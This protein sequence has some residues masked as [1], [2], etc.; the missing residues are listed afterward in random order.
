MKLQSTACPCCSDKEYADCCQ[1]IHMDPS[2]ADTP[3]QLMRSRYAAFVLNDTAHLFRT[4]APTHRPSTVSSGDHEVKWLHL[5]I[6]EAPGT[7]TET[8]KGSVTFTATYLVGTLLYTLHEESQFIKINSR[9]YYLEGKAETTQLNIGRNSR[10]PCNSGKK[11]KR[12]CG[13][14]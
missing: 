7:F 1:P 4:W 2:L 8:G 9:W 5:A 12:C 10:C 14:K 11:F 3:E 13:K 6:D